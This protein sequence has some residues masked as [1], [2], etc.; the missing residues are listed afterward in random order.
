MH[1]TPTYSHKI[2]AAPGRDDTLTA[3]I[4]CPGTW[5]DVT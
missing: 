3:V 1:P 2:I 5:Q 4:T